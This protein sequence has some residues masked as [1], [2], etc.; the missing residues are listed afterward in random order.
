[1]QL[2]GRASIL[3]VS[4]YPAACAKAQSW[5]QQGTSKA[6]AAVSAISL[7][8]LTSRC[9]V[10]GV[11]AGMGTGGW[12]ASIPPPGV[13]GSGLGSP[14]WDVMKTVRWKLLER[15]AWGCIPEKHMSVI[16]I[17]CLILAP[18]CNDACAA[19]SL[20]DLNQYVDAFGTPQTVLE[21][22]QWGL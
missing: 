9:K 21:Q 16:G 15:L 14:G 5:P 2:Q 18:T 19:S 3:T 4:P 22:F 8:A 7:K 1:M 10:A 6:G 12:V 11:A 17:L 20:P 13:K